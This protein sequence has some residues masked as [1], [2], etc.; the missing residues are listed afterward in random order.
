MLNLIYF[1]LTCSYFYV[2][3]LII[4]SLYNN[5]FKGYILFKSTNNLQSNFNPSIN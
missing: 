2:A 3:N 5:I 1:T 4:P